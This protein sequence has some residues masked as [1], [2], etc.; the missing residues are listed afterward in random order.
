MLRTI[1][2]QSKHTQY[3][4]LG[5]FPNTASAQGSESSFKD[6]VHKIGLRLI[7]TE[8]TRLGKKQEHTECIGLDKVHEHTERAQD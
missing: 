5:R 8:C 3:T 6:S 4:G 2:E 7:H 1:Q